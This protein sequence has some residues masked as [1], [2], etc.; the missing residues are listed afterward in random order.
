MAYLRFPDAVTLPGA[1]LMGFC[2]EIGVYE[3]ELVRLAPPQISC[4]P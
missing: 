2:V 4:V 3:D 1:A